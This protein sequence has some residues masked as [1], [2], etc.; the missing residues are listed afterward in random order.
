MEHHPNLRIAIPTALIVIVGLSAGAYFFM[1]TTNTP[2]V[3]SVGT[4]TP[5]VPAGWLEYTN[6]SFEISFYYPQGYSVETSRYRPNTLTISNYPQ[7][8][9]T[10][11]EDVPADWVAVDIF[12]GPQSKADW[13]AG[14]AF[15]QKLLPMLT[16]TT[17]KTADGRGTVSYYKWYSDQASD[18]SLSAGNGRLEQMN[19]FLEL[20]NGKAFSVS[21]ID[22]YEWTPAGSDE[23]AATLL[24]E[25]LKTA[26]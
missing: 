3:V 2:S 1:R 13:S 10:N 19:G 9:L 21:N 7:S 25:I 23:K 8:R 5:I 11:I 15:T 18:Y 17:E 4:T 22:N 12:A 24:P 6:S 14:L 20:G 26:H 16:A